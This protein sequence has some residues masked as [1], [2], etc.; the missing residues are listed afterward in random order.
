[1]KL[2]ELIAQIGDE[3]VT[4]QKL[5]DSITGTVSTNKQGVTKITFGT[6]EITC[7][8]LLVGTKIGLIVWIPTDK[9]PKTQS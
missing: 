4:V 8:D 7:G 5:S 3:N 9:L 1:M 2:S 6:K